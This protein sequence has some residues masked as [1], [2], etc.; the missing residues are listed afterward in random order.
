MRAPIVN[1]MF[2]ECI[3]DPTINL[4]EEKDILLS[5]DDIYM[6]ETEEED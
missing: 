5:E 4:K 2:F 1:F 6:G 3:Y